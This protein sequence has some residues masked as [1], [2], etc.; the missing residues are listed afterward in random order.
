[1]MFF[2]ALVLVGLLLVQDFLLC[3]FIFFNFK[4]YSKRDVD[5]PMVSVLLPA[6][7]EA[8]T[9]KACLK[10]F[11]SINYPPEKIEFIVGNDQSEDHT[12]QILRDW[13][14]E[15]SNR[16]Y[17]EIKTRY[18]HLN[19]KANALAQMA[20][21]ATGELLLFTDA[22]CRTNEFWVK[23]MVSAFEPRY[24]LIVGVTEVAGENIFERL[25]G[26]DWWITLGMI[27]VTADLGK[28]LTA[29]GNN[30][31]VSR[32]AYEAIGGYE[33]LGFSVT[34]DFALGQAVMEKGYDP[35]HQMTSKSLV[36]T[37]GEKSFF[38]L[39][40]QRKRWMRGA[41][42]LPFR[43]KLLLVLQALFFPAIITVLVFN[44][45]LGGAIWFGKIWVQAA[46]IKKLAHNCKGKVNWGELFIFEV[47]HLVISWSTIVYYFWPSKINWKERRY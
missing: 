39:M 33:S 35:I 28:L 9:V 11:E 3:F 8:S 30:M 37:K 40:R 15:F 36:Y 12:G 19:G 23:E 17:V 1:M 46:F 24:G 47:Y 22:D 29:V 25:Q 10:S 27:K 18:S 13:S 14:N 42:S 5:L 43:W 38:Q 31:L 45:W 7:N 34:E 2:V 41:L 26:M 32:E 4:D 20:Q 44:V 16:T 21:V 6:R